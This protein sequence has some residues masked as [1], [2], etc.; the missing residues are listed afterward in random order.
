M[1]ACQSRNL[2]VHRFRVTYVF[3]RKRR[4]RGG[5]KNHN[6]PMTKT[7][8]RRARRLGLR[9]RLEQAR[10]REECA[11]NARRRGMG[12]KLKAKS[13]RVPGGHAGNTAR[14]GA[15]TS[16]QPRWAHGRPHRPKVEITTRPV[17]GYLVRPCQP[18]RDSTGDV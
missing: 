12:D 6:I 9:L 5:Q 11:C 10:L 7:V 16:H 8:P 15:T 4:R 17:H 2:D 13:S 3:R 1:C 14:R 18:S